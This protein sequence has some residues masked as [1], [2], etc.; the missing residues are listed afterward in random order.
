[1]AFRT[2]ILIST[3]LLSSF[4][5]AKD[6][7]QS[8]LDEILSNGERRPGLYADGG[9]VMHHEARSAAAIAEFLQRELGYKTLLMTGLKTFGTPGF[10]GLILNSHNQPVANFSLKTSNRT[11][12]RALGAVIDSALGKMYRFSK[13]NEWQKALTL[14]SRTQQQWERN[15]K[16]MHRWLQLLQ[17]ESERAQ[18][19]ILH[20][21]HQ[22]VAEETIL[23]LKQRT[24]GSSPA[25][26]ILDPT[27]VYIFKDGEETDLAALKPCEDQ[28]RKSLPD[29]E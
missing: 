29:F 27:T 19:L 7:S 11:T 28:L 9:H 16:Q 23:S 24:R 6:E 4:A 10:D 1:M 15:Q 22:E 21:T 26:I 3:A 25:L 12:E 13:L 5:L 20:L 14:V 18:W 17:P 8:V 2:F